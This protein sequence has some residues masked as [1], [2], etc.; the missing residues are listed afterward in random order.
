MVTH[1]PQL[2]TSHKP[3]VDL[4]HET[5]QTDLTHK[6]QQNRSIPT[7]QHADQKRNKKK[8]RKLKGEKYRGDRRQVEEEMAGAGQS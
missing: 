8:E 6:T 3:H 1:N 4:T 2:T 7:H 5:Q